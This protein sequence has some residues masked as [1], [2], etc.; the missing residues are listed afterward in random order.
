MPLDKKLKN[1]IRNLKTGAKVL[2]VGTVITTYLASSVLQPLSI[3]P[4]SENENHL[5]EPNTIT[6]HILEAGDDLVFPSYYFDL[7]NL[8]FSDTSDNLNSENTV[9]VNIDPDFSTETIQRYITDFFGWVKDNSSETIQNQITNFS[10]DFL[11]IHKKSTYFPID[12]K[13]RLTY[14]PSE[15]FDLENFLRFM[16]G[17]GQF[18]EGPQFMSAVN[19]RKDQRSALTLF[20][21]LLHLWQLDET[22]SHPRHLINYVSNNNHSTNGDV[23]NFLHEGFATHYSEKA[24][25]DLYL[26]ETS[27]DIPLTNSYY[28]NGGVIL[29]K[30]PIDESMDLCQ[31]IARTHNVSSDELI[32]GFSLLFEKTPYESVIP[33]LSEIHKEDPVDIIYR[34]GENFFELLETEFNGT[35]DQ[36]RKLRHEYTFSKKD[37]DEGK[38]NEALEKTYGLTITQVEDKYKEVLREHNCGF[39]HF[40]DFEKVR[41]EQINK[42]LT[43][44]KEIDR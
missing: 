14:K 27:L 44:Y 31:K 5:E 18:Q 24:I 9:K 17:S 26:N 4:N 10:I 41:Q 22:N 36:A 21:E 8:T 2:A 42:A 3:A 39:D 25:K 16:V 33:E 11:S 13:I 19:D 23:D 38:L 29:N 40:R 34:H 28:G 30:I 43:Q 35:L 37:T 6:E 15:I 12:N 1:V 20:H 7:E 32:D